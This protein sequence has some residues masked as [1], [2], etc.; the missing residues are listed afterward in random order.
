MTGANQ[1]NPRS[2]RCSSSTLHSNPMLQCRLAWVTWQH[3]NMPWDDTE[4]WVADV[5]PDG[6]LTGQRKVSL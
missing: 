1:P 2:T 3:P 5:A 6:G 4:L